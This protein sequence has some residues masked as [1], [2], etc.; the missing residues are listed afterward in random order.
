MQYLCIGGAFVPIASFCSNFLI[1]QG[2]SQVYMWNTVALC[3]VQLL[4]LVVLHPYGVRC[5]VVAYVA[6]HT[7]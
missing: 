2:K 6:A 5:M 1:S 3:L 7:L 4:L